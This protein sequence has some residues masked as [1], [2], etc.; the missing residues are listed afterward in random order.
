LTCHYAK[1]KQESLLHLQGP[2]AL[3]FLQG[4]VTCDTRK[5]GECNSLAGVLCTV[6]GRVVGDFL[7]CALAQNHLVLRLRR[8]I[9]AAFAAVLGKYIVF[10]KA[11]LEPERE[12]WQVLACWGP[13]AAAALLDIFGTLPG[14]KYGTRVGAG[15]ALLQTDDAGHQFECYLRQ[16]TAENF[17]QQLAQRMDA[18]TEADWQALQI[19]A[20]IARIEAGTTGEF[21]PQMLNYD[22]T[23]HISFNKGCYTGQE[24]VARMHYRG[25][26]KRRLY[27]AAVDRS[28]LPAGLP[29][30]AGDPLFGGD[31]SRA[32]GNIVNAVATAD[33][34]LVLLVT[35][36]A[37]GIETGLHLA[38][39][40]GPLLRTEPVPYT[41]PEK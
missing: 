18:G 37:S 20:G 14:E 7:L 23:G 35:A 26:P 5:L 8:D 39:P 29:V 41:V 10:S 28:E 15:F 24:V 3:S 34:Q 19:A 4:Q 22:V 11:Q 12:D 30:T 21:I 27:R 25:K 32:A 36:T 1:L 38:D 2:D 17:L 13:G 31:S 40:D 9:R 33:D 16:D 6:Q